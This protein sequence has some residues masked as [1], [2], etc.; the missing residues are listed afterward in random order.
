M[1]N[2]KN[3]YYTI[4]EETPENGQIVVA[5]GNAGRALCMYDKDKNVF[6][7][8]YGR[9]KEIWAGTYGWMEPSQENNNN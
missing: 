2:K 7:L 8:M 4:E 5:W 3:Y 9:E 6:Y 1:A